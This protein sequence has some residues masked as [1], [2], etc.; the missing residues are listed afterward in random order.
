MKH[1]RRRLAIGSRNLNKEFKWIYENDPDY[2]DWVLTTGAAETESQREGDLSDFAAY[3]KDR[4]DDGILNIGMHRGSWYSEIYRTDTTGYCD[5]VLRQPNP[6]PQLAGF[7]QFIRN[8]RKAGGRQSEKKVEKDAPGRAPIAWDSESSS[9]SASSSSSP[10]KARKK[11]VGKSTSKAKKEKESGSKVKTKATKAMKSTEVQEAKAEAARLKAEAKAE[12][13]RLKAEAAQALKEAEKA[14]Q[15]AKKA[16]SSARQAKAEADALK[17]RRASK[18]NET[19]TRKSSAGKKSKKADSDEEQT[20]ECQICLDAKVS[21]VFIP[22]GHTACKGCGPL[23]A[24]KPCPTCRTRVTK[25]Q[26]FFI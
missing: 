20:N 21:I 16:E 9:S 19:S 4:R 3:L 18:S 22:C 8:K 10:T 2:C 5:W 13:A 14:K 12:A 26:R 6:S 25:V 23:F 15:A 11:A 24:D 1:D 17:K 7:A